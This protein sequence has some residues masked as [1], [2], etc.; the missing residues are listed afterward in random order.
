MPFEHDRRALAVLFDTFWSPAGWKREYR[1]DPQDLA[2]AIEAGYMFA[3]EELA[4]DEVVARVRQAAEA[5]DPEAVAHAFLFSL[6]SRRLELR[7]ALGSYA[8]ARVFPRHHLIPWPAGYTTLGE[9]AQCCCCPKATYDRSML[10]FERLKW[11]GARHLHDPYYCA[12]DLEQF[13]RLEVPRASDADRATLRQILDLARGMPA[14]ARPQDLGRAIGKLIPSNRWER[15]AL[16]NILG[17]C[18]ILAAP[19]RPGFDERWIP[20]RER[21]LPPVWKL[22]WQYP[23]AWW[24]GGGVSAEAVERFFPG[25]WG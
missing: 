7:S 5:T 24:R 16:L 3:P 15:W 11:G 4:H 25:L 20:E 22:D 2:Y 12:F 19:G 17:F 6:R 13:A 9:C 1:T 14:T 23:V 18:G 10:N 21:T 8:I